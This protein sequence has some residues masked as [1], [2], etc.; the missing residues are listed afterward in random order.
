MPITYACASAVNPAR[1]TFNTGSGAFAFTPTSNEVGAA[2]FNFTAT[3]KDGAS[4]PVALNV[5]VAVPQA[6]SPSSLAPTNGAAAVLSIGS[7]AGVT[8]ALE[9]TTD[10][11]AQPP[12]WLPADEEPARVARSSCRMR[13][14][15]MRSGTTA[16]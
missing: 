6:V 2:Q 14:R 1:W 5:T 11:A 10:L 16:W 15:R 7:Q 13:I 8:Y 3:D 4:A 9:Y 12:V